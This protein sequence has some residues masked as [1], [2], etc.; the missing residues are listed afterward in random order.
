MLSLDDFYHDHATLLGLGRSRGLPGTHDLPL[1]AQ[2]LDALCCCGGAPT[3]T[4]TNTV[5]PSTTTTTLAPIRLPAYDKSAH[6]GQGDR[7]PLEQCPLQE[8]PVDV[9]LLEGWMLGYQPLTDTTD[10][11]TSTTTSITTTSATT[12][13]RNWESNYGAS[14]AEFHEI[15]GNLAAYVDVWRDRVD[16]FVYLFPSDASDV[17]HGGHG[18]R[19]GVSDHPPQHD[20]DDDK[21]DD[22]PHSQTDSSQTTTTTTT[23]TAANHLDWIY[24]WRRE[25]EDSLRAAKGDRDAGMTDQQVRAFVDQFMPCY[26]LYNHRH[27]LAHAFPGKPWLRIEVDK[28]RRVVRSDAILPSLIP[29]D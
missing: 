7:M 25:Q 28:Q 2:T 15:N 8:L 5:S 19:G 22:R 16:A 1:L 9:V 14:A 11:S 10:I 4:T 26:R 24:D 20:D 18:E 17:G 21:D 12:T 3:T 13:T 27:R 29:T 23:I 6:H